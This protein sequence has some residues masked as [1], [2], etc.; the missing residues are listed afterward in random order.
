VRLDVEVDQ[1]RLKELLDYDPETGLFRWRVDSA[2]HKANEIAGATISSGYRSIGI[3]GRRYKAGHLAW[4]Y[5]TGS[6]PDSRV[7]FRDKNPANTAWSNLC[8]SKGLFTANKPP[9]KSNKLGVKA[10]ASGEMGKYQAYIFVEGRQRWLGT[11][12]ELG[13]SAAP[14]AAEAH[15]VNQAKRANPAE[16]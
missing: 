4:L 3:D 2:H 16:D 10:C 14:P 13:L 8:Q 15:Y 7:C 1:S 12:T 9:L 6:W 11:T 5:M